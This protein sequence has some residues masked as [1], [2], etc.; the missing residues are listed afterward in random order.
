[1]KSYWLAVRLVGDDTML[2]RAESVSILPPLPPG[3]GWGEG[4]SGKNLWDGGE[5]HPAAATLSSSRRWR[6]AFGLHR[7]L[8]QQIAAAPRRWQELVVEIVAV[9]EHDE[10]RVAHRRLADDAAGVERHR[11]DSCPNPAC[12]T[13]RPRAC[14]RA[15]R[16]FAARLVAPLWL[17]RTN[18]RAL[19]LR[20]AQA[21]RPPPPAPRGTGGSRPS[22]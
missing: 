8:A 1:M 21:S 16:R 14:R 10:R 12:A 13:R 2:R 4:D 18:G 17:G 9:G 15:C 7:R 11:Q 5:H 6:A 20:G 19:Q 3:E 22:S